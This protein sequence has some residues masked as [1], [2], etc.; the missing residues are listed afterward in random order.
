[1]PHLIPLLAEA[2]VEHAESANKFLMLAEHFGLNWKLLLAQAVNFVLVAYLLHRLA[3]KPVLA[4]LEERQRRIAEG[5]QNAE[6]AR[7]ALADA[8]QR[9]EETLAKARA[10]AQRLITE[11]RDSAKHLFDQKVQETSRQI[12]HMLAKGMEANELER[13]KMLAEVRQEIARLVVLTSG[14]VLQRTLGD[15]ERRRINEAAAQ[16]IASAN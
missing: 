8:R 9:E 16:E 10:E 12:E 7:L 1:M 15:D 11:A 5:L 3:F 6:D 13:Q 2:A 14:R 4:A